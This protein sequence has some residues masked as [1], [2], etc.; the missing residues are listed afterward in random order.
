LDTTLACDGIPADRG[1]ETV[2]DVAK[3]FTQRAWHENVES[4]WRDGSLLLSA[5]NEYD[6]QGLALMDEFSDAISAC[7]A[8]DFG[9]S[10][11]LVSAIGYQPL[12]R[13]RVSQRVLSEKLRL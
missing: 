5:E 6:R 3:E 2:A 4:T 10:I 1:P 11:R 8:A 13:F 9:Y 7:T 12:K